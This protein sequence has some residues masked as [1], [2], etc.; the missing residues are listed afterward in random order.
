MR[1]ATFSVKS[2]NSSTLLAGTYVTNLSPVV[3]SRHTLAITP[4]FNVTAQFSLVRRAH[5]PRICSF[6]KKIERSVTFPSAN[7]KTVRVEVNGS[8]SPGRIANVCTA[9]KTFSLSYLRQPA[10]A[11][12]GGGLGGLRGISAAQH[13]RT[14]A[15]RLDPAVLASIA[16]DNKEPKPHHIRVGLLA[17]D[18]SRFLRQLTNGERVYAVAATDGAACALVERLRIPHAYNLKK[19]ASDWACSRLTRHV[20]TTIASFK[21]NP[22]S[23]VFSWGIALDSVT[24]VSW[25]AGKQGVI[26]VPVRHNAWAHL[27]N[28]SFKDFTVHFADGRAEKIP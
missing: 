24:A 6:T 26:T 9:F 12:G 21:A 13:P 28:A 10:L 2:V 25:M 8:K 27:G 15:D 14:K 18:S 11:G 16:L 7:G 22:Q 20:P 23:P 3:L 1:V 4:L 19:P 17:P 5:G